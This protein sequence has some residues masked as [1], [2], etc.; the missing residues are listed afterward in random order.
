VR[1]EL[2]G[3]ILRRGDQQRQSRGGKIV[4]VAGDPFLTGW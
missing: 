1:I 4:V 2:T 3:G